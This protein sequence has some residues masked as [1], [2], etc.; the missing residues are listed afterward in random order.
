[1]PRRAEY[2]PGLQAL[3]G[4]LAMC[5]FCQHMFASA[6]ILTPGPTKELYVL[7]L[8]G[9]GVLTFFALSGFLIP[10]K[11]GDPAVKFLMDRSRRIFPIWWLTLGFAVLFMWLHGVPIPF[12]LDTAFLIPNGRPN[13]FALPQWSLYFEWFFYVLVMLVA[14][15]QASWVRPAVVLWG[16]VTFALYQRPYD[17]AHYN[18]PNLYSLVFPL[19]GL[20]FA[21]GVLA[22]WRFTPAPK[23]AAPY[24][25][26]AIGAY[27]AMQTAG[28]TGLY[29]YLPLSIRIE[30]TGFAL[31]ALGAFFAIRAALCWQPKWFLGRALKMLGDASYG[32][33]LIHTLFMDLAL[34]LIEAVHT[35][36]SYALCTMLIL[37]IALPP[38][39]LFGLF[40]MKLQQ[41]L[42]HVR[43]GIA[44][45]PQAK[46]Q[47]GRRASG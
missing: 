24:G 25:L 28:W 10:S 8:G 12:W 39:I 7:Q 6:A 31:T 14:L 47:A 43:R 45:R 22:G 15:V 13:P 44:A 20:Y 17:F 34:R 5:V 30:D 23:K 33:Y 46:A 2:H 21:V 38:S 11:A 41:F 3:R 36:N 32:I 35:P 29:I 40:D 18:F 19:Y 37:L 4:I 1:M 9:V 26:A 16:V 42:K 27:Y